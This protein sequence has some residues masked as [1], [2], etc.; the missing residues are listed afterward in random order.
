MKGTIAFSSLYA[1]HLDTSVWKDPESFVPERFLDENG[2]FSV[3]LDKSL[4]FGAGKRL[5]AGETFARNSLFL[6]ATA[7]MQNFNIVKSECDR[8]PDPKETHTGFAR[9][10]PTFW[11]KLVPREH[12]EKNTF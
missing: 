10:I 12:H 5:C 3:K 2:K 9:V 6:V 8:I 1:S 7:L 11:V 4:P